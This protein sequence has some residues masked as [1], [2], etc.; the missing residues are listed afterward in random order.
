MMGSGPVV[1]KLFDTY[2]PRHLIAVGSFLHVF[3]LMMASIATEYY[4]FLLA[5]GVCSAIGI[6]CIFQPGESDVASMLPS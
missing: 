4:Q 3:G 6:A 5:Q 2:G 1:G